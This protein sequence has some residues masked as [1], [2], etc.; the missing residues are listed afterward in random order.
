MSSKKRHQVSGVGCALI[1][2]F[3]MFESCQTA[4]KQTRLMTSAG[5]IEI[6]KV[7]LIIRNHHFESRFSSIVEK[8]A[9]EIASQTKD[10]D[11]RK[12]T[13]LWKMYAIPV[14]QKAIFQYDPLAALIDV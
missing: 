8:A 9:D 10:P 3:F 12:N 13:L 7:E 14:A 2:S 1:L 4:P 5:E 11:I 6:L